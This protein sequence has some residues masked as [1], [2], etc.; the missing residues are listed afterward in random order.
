MSHFPIDRTVTRA[1]LNEFH[2]S[3]VDVL[4]SEPAKRQRMTSLLKA[5]SYDCAHQER[6]VF[7][8]ENDQACFPILSRVVALGDRSVFLERNITLP[9]QSICKV[10]FLGIPGRLFS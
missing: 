6:I 1:I 8:V 3:R 10:Q 7:W 5:L 2:A 4:H 9:I